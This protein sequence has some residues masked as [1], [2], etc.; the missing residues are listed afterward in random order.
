MTE[1]AGTAIAASMYEERL[2]G[3]GHR[4]VCYYCRDLCDATAGDPGEWPVALC[5]REE[6]GVVYFHHTRCVYE[7]LS[8]NQPAL[9]RR[10]EV[11]TDEC[12]KLCRAA[13]PFLQEAAQKADYLTNNWNPDAHVELTVTIAELRALHSAVWPGP[14]KGDAK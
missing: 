14:A 5:H 7:R 8:E 10:L 13:M 12:D 3:Q 2:R 1:S 4:E 6:P 11:A 9:A